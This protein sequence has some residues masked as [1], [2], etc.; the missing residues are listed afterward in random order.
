VHPLLLGDQE[1]GRVELHADGWAASLHG[2]YLLDATGAGARFRSPA[3]AAATV[4]QLL[5]S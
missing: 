1:V 3:E 5:L 4:Y 2:R